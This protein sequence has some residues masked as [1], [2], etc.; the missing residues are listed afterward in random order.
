MKLDYYRAPRSGKQ[1]SV[2]LSDATLGA[3]ICIVLCGSILMG[4]QS[5]DIGQLIGSPAIV[6]LTGVLGVLLSAWLTPLIV[7]RPIH[8]PLEGILPFAGIWLIGC[9]A[10]WI[11]ES[12]FLGAIVLTW[13]GS[14]LVW[15]MC[16]ERRL[17]AAIAIM[18]LSWA[19]MLLAGYLFIFILWTIIGR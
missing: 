7:K 19:G 6:T 17:L 11:P 5:W 15:W 13:S 18:T 12:L 1:G 8:L 4:L 2:L 9:A 10:V 3:C 16:V 14:I